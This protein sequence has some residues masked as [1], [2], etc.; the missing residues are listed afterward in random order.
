MHTTAPSRWFS[1][2]LPDAVAPR[3]AALLL[4]SLALAPPAGADVR[5]DYL[6]HCGGC[7]LPDGRGAP[8]KVPDFRNELSWLLTTQQGRDYLVQVPG[9]SQAPV[10]DERLGQ[11]VNWLLTEYNAETLPADFRPLTTEEVSAAR[12]HVLTNPVES[13]RELLRG[14]RK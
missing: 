5:S 8:P 2:K 9:A 11:I 1:A 10:S 13:R 7:H 6:L 12:R 3:L 4:A 14:Y